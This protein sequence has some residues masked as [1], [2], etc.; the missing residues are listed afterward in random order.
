M[1]RSTPLPLV[2][3]LL[4]LQFAA[5]FLFV[6]GF[7]L[8]RHEVTDR[9]TCEASPGERS[10]LCTNETLATTRRNAA[11]SSF[12]SP[13]FDRAIII[14]IDALRFDF[15]QW[16]EEAEGKSDG[17]DS[18][19]SQSISALG[20]HHHYFRNKL[21]SIH[22]ALSKHPNNAILLPC[23]ADPPTT[24]MQRLKALTTGSLPTF[25]DVSLNFNSPEISEDNLIDQLRNHGRLLS[26][27]GDDTWMSL[28]PRHFHH[29]H[30]YPS[31]NVK[32]LHTVDTGV[33]AHLF[34]ELAE[35]NVKEQADV[36]IA[37]FLGVDHVGHTFGPE[38]ATMADKLTQLDAV[39]YRV[40]EE[41][42]ND[43]LLLVFGDHGMTWDGN[44][45]GA[46]EDEVRAA[47]FAYSKK[48]FSL[49]EMYS[50]KRMNKSDKRGEDGNGEEKNDKR[51]QHIPVSVSSSSSPSSSSESISGF[52]EHGVSQVDIVPTLAVLLGVPIPF[53][54]LGSFISALTPVDA[55]GDE[56]PAWF[57]VRAL[58]SNAWQV[59]RY[60]KRYAAVAADFSDARM[61]P[62]NALFE[63]ANARYADIHAE[64]S[65]DLRALSWDTVEVVEASR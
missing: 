31:F 16:E 20:R 27:M 15:V 52:L 59:A 58:R 51:D 17:G 39:L 60:L 48:P 2:A 1:P 21:P 3:L 36:I 5:A 19:K 55:G 8:T 41:M 28:F 56:S 23:W 4:C 57:A 11:E 7:L 30:P 22:D 54:N 38:H 37:H 63:Q 50:N 42:K 6:H 47:L 64:S 46:S 62:L 44:H 65:D 49:R 10:R 18:H 29:C 9:A 14:V 32:D 34:P 45:G 12:T 43:T 33:I 26:F 53:A 25:V 35:Q 24:T 13:A 61:A 40:M